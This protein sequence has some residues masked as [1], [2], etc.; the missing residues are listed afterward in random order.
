MSEPTNLPDFKFLLTFILLS[1]IS[2]VSQGLISKIVNE[3]HAA[4]ETGTKIRTPGKD[5]KR[6]SGLVHVD[7]FDMV[8]MQVHLKITITVNLVFNKL[9]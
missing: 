7:D 3:G 6:K 1:Y 9:F 5:R 4:E 8:C 2:G